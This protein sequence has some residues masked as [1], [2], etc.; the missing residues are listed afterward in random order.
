[1]RII[2]TIITFL[3]CVVVLLLAVMSNASNPTAS[4]LETMQLMKIVSVLLCIY[5]GFLLILG[6]DK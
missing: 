3:F 5:A 1:M 2:N 6:G 4:E